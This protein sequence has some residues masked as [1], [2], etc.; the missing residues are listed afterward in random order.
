MRNLLLANLAAAALVACSPPASQQAPGETPNE[1]PTQT[2]C[3]NVAPNAAQAVTLEGDVAVAAAVADLR[4]GRVTPGLYDLASGARNGAATGWTGAR[5]VS[6]EV[7]ELETGT[8]FNWASAAPGSSDVER[9]TAGFIDSPTAH[10]TY[11][12]GKTGGADV[13]FNAEPNGLRLRL[14]DENGAGSLLLTFA[15]RT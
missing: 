14:P 10:L 7:T 13:E 3:N 15:R 11:T 8:T 9:W 2:A 1:I 5:S 12:C 6:L 4:G